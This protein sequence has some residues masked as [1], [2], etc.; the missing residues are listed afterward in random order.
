MMSLMYIRN[1]HGLSTEPWRAPHLIG[2]SG[3]VC[4]AVILN[5]II[6]END[7]WDNYA[8]NSEGC[9][10]YRLNVTSL[11]GWN[12]QQV[13]GLFEIDEDTYSEFSLFKRFIMFMILPLSYDELRE[14]ARCTKSRAVSGNGAILPARDFS[15]GPARSK[16]IIFLAL[17]LVS[18]PFKDFTLFN[19][20][21]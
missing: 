12:D 18:G 5:M 6:I 7:S 10:V 11:G 14:E 8:S 13:K 15:F 2:S 21:I 17:C 19:T 16:I 4:K 20:K 1:N 9:L 3:D